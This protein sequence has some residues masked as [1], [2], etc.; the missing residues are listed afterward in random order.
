MPGLDI[1]RRHNTSSW[2]PFGNCW[3]DRGV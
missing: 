2:H 1:F 3:F